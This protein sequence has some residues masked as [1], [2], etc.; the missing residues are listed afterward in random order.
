MDHVK[1]LSGI[2]RFIALSIPNSHFTQC[3]WFVFGYN[4]HAL[5]LYLVQPGQDEISNFS[6]TDRANRMMAPFASL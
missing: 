1:W 2:A 4:F 3:I 5:S 6:N